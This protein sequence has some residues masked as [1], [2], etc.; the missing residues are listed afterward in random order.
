MAME[1]LEYFHS[2]FIRAFL[3]TNM[4]ISACFAFDSFHLLFCLVD[5]YWLVYFTLMVFPTMEKR[6]SLVS[7]SI[8]NTTD[9]FSNLETEPVKVGTSASD[10]V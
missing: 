2:F 7:S 5:N 6:T 8:R 10:R 3:K 4:E 1:V 9:T